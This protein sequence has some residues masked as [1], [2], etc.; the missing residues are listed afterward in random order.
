MRF[1]EIKACAER[2]AKNCQVGAG[3]AECVGIYVKI[4]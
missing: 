1:V 4:Y 3:L 2:E